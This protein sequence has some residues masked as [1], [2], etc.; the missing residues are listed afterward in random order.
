MPTTARSNSPNL[1]TKAVLVMWLIWGITNAR[2]IGAA[3]LRICLLD[4]ANCIFY[5]QEY[6]RKITGKRAKG[7]G[8]GQHTKKYS[9]IAKINRLDYEQHYSIAHGFYGGGSENNIGNGSD[10]LRPADAGGPSAFQLCPAG[11]GPH[12]VHRPQIL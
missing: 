12:A 1:P 6:G 10:Y 5:G 7:G 9:I 8:G 11:R 4:M 2:L 3:I